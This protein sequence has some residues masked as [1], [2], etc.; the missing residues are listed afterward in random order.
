MT[1]DLALIQK[2]GESGLNK[3]EITELLGILPFDAELYPI[4]IYAN[5]QECSAMG[6]ITN[7]AADKLD[8]D[9]EASGLNTFIADIL[10]DIN[11]ESADS[12]YTFKGINIMLRY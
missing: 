4:E 10:D 12:T 6:F 9:Y 8:F 7:D 2:P 1:F 11:R 5:A 3:S